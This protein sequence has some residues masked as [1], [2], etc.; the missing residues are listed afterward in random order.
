MF[1]QY[2]LFA[3]TT[4]NLIYP[5][6]VSRLN[7]VPYFENSTTEGS[8]QITLKVQERTDSVVFHVRDIKIDEHSVTI[9]S[10]KPNSSQ[11]ES[12]SQEYL[13]GHKYK[14]VFKDTLEQ[15]EEYVLSLRF[16]GSLNG[17]LQG[18]YM[19][20]YTGSDGQKR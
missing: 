8:V 11:L 1:F 13:D 3:V 5:F 9:E 16:K 10:T 12:G 15:G 18:F 7:I 2:I 6:H 19:S 17:H 20:R 14:I 4:W